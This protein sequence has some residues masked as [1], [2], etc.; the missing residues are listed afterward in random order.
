M[1]R[2]NRVNLSECW[3][4]TS[5]YYTPGGIGDPI[6]IPLYT[7]EHKRS[8]IDKRLRIIRKLYR[9]GMPIKDIAK[10]KGVCVCERQVKRH[11]KAMGLRRR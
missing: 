10:T 2:Q 7:T 9:E 8:D 4:E 1:T 6:S 11:L 3:L 5:M